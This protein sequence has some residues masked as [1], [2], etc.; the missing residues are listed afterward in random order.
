MGFGFCVAIFTEL[1][2]TEI[3]REGKIGDVD[4]CRF[5]SVGRVRRVFSGVDSEVYRANGGIVWGIPLTPM[6]TGG[7]ASFVEG[8]RRRHNKL[9]HQ[10]WARLHNY[11]PGFSI[12]AFIT[13]IPVIVAGRP[14]N[15]PS[16]PFELTTSLITLL[17]FERSVEGYLLLCADPFSKVYLLSRLRLQE[18]LEGI[19][20]ELR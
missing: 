17:L 12:A 6:G 9:S 18:F 13:D 20:S 3:G 7:N 8:P 10:E 4:G 16:N 11:C 2:C 1:G 5:G 15:A 19:D 14:I